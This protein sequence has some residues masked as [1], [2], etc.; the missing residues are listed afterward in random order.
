MR[1]V[2]EEMQSGVYSEAIVEFNNRMDVLQLNIERM[3]MNLSNQKIFGAYC[4]YKGLT[5]K[6]FVDE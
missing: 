3:K 4:D 1:F 2:T 5:V 6:R